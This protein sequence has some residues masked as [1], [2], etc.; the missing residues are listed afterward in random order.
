MRNRGKTDPGDVRDGCSIRRAD[1]E[2]LPIIYLRWGRRDGGPRTVKQVRRGETF[3]ARVRATRGENSPIRKQEG[4]GI[5]TAKDS[6]AGKCSPSASRRIPE[7]R[8][9]SRSIGVVESA[10]SAAARDQDGPIREN[11]SI[12]LLAGIRHGIGETPRRIGNIQIN[13]L[14]RGGWRIVRSTQ[15]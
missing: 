5:I 4:D 6:R 8:S 2:T 10:T 1:R 14:S 11:R 7:F 3:A 13:R 15:D 12:R 9:Q